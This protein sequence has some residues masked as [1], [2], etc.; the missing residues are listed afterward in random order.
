MPTQAVT[1]LTTA[2]ALAALASGCVIP[3]APQ[4]DDPEANYPPYVITSTPTV[5][6]IFTPGMTDDNRQITVTLSDQNLHDNLYVRFLVD[7][8]GTDTS[9]SHLFLQFELAPTGVAARDS[10]RFRPVCERLGGAGYHR[11]LMAVSD[12]PYQDAF[13]GQAVDPEAPLDTVPDDA[14]R[15]RVSWYLNCP[16]G[17]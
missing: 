11:L 15:I 8:P 12:R 5:G 2:L 16:G 3:L 1:P 4:F 17:S 14:N 6:E 13:L 10:V 7:Y 9:N